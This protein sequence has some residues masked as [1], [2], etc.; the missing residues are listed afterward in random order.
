MFD[1]MFK[2][3][4][5]ATSHRTRGGITSVVK[6]HEQ[7]SQWKEYNC[8]WIETHVDTSKLM[9]LCYLFRSY[10]QFLFYLPVTKIT[11][12]HLSEPGSAMRKLLFFFPAH[13][14]RKKTI[15]HFHAFSPDTT[16]NGRKQWIYRY[17]FNRATKVI[18]L[19]NIWKEI[20]YN[21]FQID[22]IEV[23]YNPCTTVVSD[24]Q[25][26]KQKNILYAGA[27]NAR[28]GYSDLIRAF[29]KIASENKDWKIVFAG[30]GEIE[31]GIALA[32]EL[33]IENQCHFL[34]WIN[35][36]DKDKAFKEAS[37][38]CLPSYAEGFPMAVL[39]AWSYGLPV[40]TTPVGGMPDIA[41]DGEN[42][43]IFTPGN[44]EKLA[45]CMQ[46]LIED[47]S[48]Y[49]KI[50]KASIDFAEKDFSM[51]EINAQIGNVYYNLI[52]Y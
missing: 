41:K 50:S 37:I 34:G 31:K 11:H 30:N 42:M 38:F 32:K 16:I 19:S 5:L 20:V 23:I 8:K 33:G 49:K 24:K 26:T 7:G 22:N 1:K 4:V 52:N 17:I 12:I 13:L 14:F 43:L 40:I 45:E 10:I 28:K 21:A 51:K 18:V 48:L 39:D 15:V 36:E 27:I 9:A 25:Y 47:C 44:I 35:G 6:A 3:L 29:A 2:T 46:T